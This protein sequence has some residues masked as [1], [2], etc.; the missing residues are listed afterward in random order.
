M[1]ACFRLMFKR[2][3]K[4]FYRHELAN[5]VR[6]KLKNVLVQ[7]RLKHKLKPTPLNVRKTRNVRIYFLIESC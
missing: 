1:E 7:T 2:R 3:E 5:K 4:K 6:I